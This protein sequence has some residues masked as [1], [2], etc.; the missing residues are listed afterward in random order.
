MNKVK[1][2]LIPVLCL[3]GTVLFISS[4]GEL[5][6]EE[7]DKYDINPTS[8]EFRSQQEVSIED[9]DGYVVMQLIGR[10][11]SC[12]HSEFSVFGNF[13]DRSDRAGRVSVEG[14]ELDEVENDGKIRYLKSLVR[15]GFDIDQIAEVGVVSCA[16]ESI[17]P[18]KYNSFSEDFSFPSSLCANSS[19]GKS[20]VLS[21][22]TDLTLTWNP[23][24][25]TDVLYASVCTPGNP[26]IVKEFEDTGSATISSEEFS[27]FVNGEPVF[28][29]V[30]RGVGSVI[31]Q[32]NGIKI[33]VMRVQWSNYPRL[34]VAE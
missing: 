22:S 19:I 23:D 16:L 15:P 17:M 18:D 7:N 27:N 14:I 20:E 33:G 11:G 10:I 29:Y 6:D 9:V 13:N 12:A 3:L 32:P 24:E 34:I 21:K 8:I 25:G 2:N 26:C 5:L 28:L 1:L 30:G 31:E 4:C